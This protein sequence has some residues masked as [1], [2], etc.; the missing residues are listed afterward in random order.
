MPSM[1][2]KF[3]QQV[4]ANKA[5]RFLSHNEMVRSKLIAEEKKRRRAEV[6]QY[7]ISLPSELS[8]RQR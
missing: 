2:L 3:D 4:Q 5:K 7:D 8:T 1:T 6:G